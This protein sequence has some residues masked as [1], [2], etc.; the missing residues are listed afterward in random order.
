MSIGTVEALRQLCGKWET[1]AASIRRVEF[2]DW[3]TEYRNN[4]NDH[5]TYYV[6][7][8]F[9]HGAQV[10]LVRLVRR[11]DRRGEIEWLEGANGV[12]QDILLSWQ[13]SVS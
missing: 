11:Q 4:R 10:G 8:F 9:E 7:T 1:R 12:G 2:V 13:K 5:Y 6:A 3:G